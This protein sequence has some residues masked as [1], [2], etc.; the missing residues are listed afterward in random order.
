MF[1]SPKIAVIVTVIALLFA[2]D[3]VVPLPAF[4]SKR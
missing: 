1:I 4:E 3:E 2:A